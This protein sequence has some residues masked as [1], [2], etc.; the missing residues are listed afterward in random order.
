[1]TLGR[2][3]LRINVRSSTDPNI[4]V[5]TMYKTLI[6]KSDLLEISS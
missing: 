5:R 6:R 1:M 3:S 2:M 4:E